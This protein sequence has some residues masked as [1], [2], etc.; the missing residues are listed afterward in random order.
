MKFWQNF[1]QQ[2]L[3]YFQCLFLWDH[4]YYVFPAFG[5]KVRLVLFKSHPVPSIA[6]V[7]Q[8]RGNY[9]E[10]FLSLMSLPLD[11]MLIFSSHY[12]TTQLLHF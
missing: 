4:H 1:T 10:H 9:L 7:F 3:L 8:G 6:L 5:G 2:L 11:I 12:V